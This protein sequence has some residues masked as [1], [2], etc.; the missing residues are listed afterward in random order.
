MK[1]TNK[2]KSILYVC[3]VLIVLLSLYANAFIKERNIDFVE[4]VNEGEINIY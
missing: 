4:T 2:Q 1:L 3:V